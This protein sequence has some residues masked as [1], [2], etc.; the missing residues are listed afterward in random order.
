MLPRPRAAW[1][2]TASRTRGRASRRLR[3]SVAS[4][5]ARGATTTGSRCAASLCAGS[6]QRPNGSLPQRSHH[7]AEAAHLARHGDR[8]PATLRELGHGVAVL[9]ERRRR[10]RGG[11]ALAEVERVHLLL[12]GDV[13]ERE[14]AA[15]DPRRLRVQTPSASAVAQAASTALPPALSAATPAAE[16]S[17]WSD[18]TAACGGPTAAA[19]RW[20]GA[21]RARRSRR[22]AAGDEGRRS[23]SRKMRA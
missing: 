3:S 6:T 14:P 21:R 10:D 4:A 7:L 1:P 20:P 8:Q 19:A 9:E 23:E 2:R 13:D 12:L 11:R 5:L 22:R 17:G 15:A 18:A 16:A